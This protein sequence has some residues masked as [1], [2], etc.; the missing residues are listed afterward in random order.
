MDSHIKTWLENNKI[1]FE[2]GS[3]IMS[4]IAILIAISAYY[5]TKVQNRITHET[6]KPRF[7]V[8]LRFDKYNGKDERY[9]K[10]FIDVYAENTN[11]SNL[12][13]IPITIINYNYQDKD[14]GDRMFQLGLSNLFGRT[15]EIDY[16]EKKVTTFFGPTVSDWDLN[17]EKQLEKNNPYN[18]EKYSGIDEV[19]Y[20][21]IAY[22][23]LLGERQFDYFMVGNPC[24]KLEKKEGEKIFNWFNS[25]RKKKRIIN[26]LDLSNSL[27]NK[28][29]SEIIKDK[30]KENRRRQLNLI[31]E[32]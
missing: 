17:I 1:F 24:V 30:I 12:E 4:I 29:N 28:I 15:Y 3:I 14:F 19:H 32:Y 6:V 22:N 5:L 20:L 26:T 16:T 11:F 13:M 21:K 23:D 25:E 8:N 10:C 18:V 2:I 27:F 31:G 7:K 9:K